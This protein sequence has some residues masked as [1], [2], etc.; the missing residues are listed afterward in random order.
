M[1][2]QLRDPIHLYKLYSEKRPVGMLEK[3]SPF[4]LSVANN[5]PNR[6]QPWYKAQPMGINKLYNILKDMK[7]EADMLTDKKSSTTR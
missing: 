4:F 6:L 1:N 7:M 3:D 5:S 2:D